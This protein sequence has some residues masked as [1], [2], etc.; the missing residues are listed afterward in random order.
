MAANNQFTTGLGKIKFAALARPQKNRT[1]P[2][3]LEYTIKLDIDGNSPEGMSLKKHLAAINPKKIVTV[4]VT[5]D[6]IVEDG[7]F[8]VS[9]ST[10]RAPLIV[11]EN[12]DELK[13][14]DVPFFDSRVDTGEASVVYMVGDYEGKKYIR[15]VAVKLRNIV[16]APREGS[17]SSNKD[18]IL[19]MINS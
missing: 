14:A 6:R 2:T 9:F 12:G 17:V 19:A 5:G 18:E 11:A 10:N 16:I 7:H 1:D 15:L 3:K 8:L 13:G 4:N